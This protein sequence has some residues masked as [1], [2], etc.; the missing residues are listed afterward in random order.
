MQ[1]GFSEKNNFDFSNLKIIGLSEAR[2]NFIGYF[3]AR[4]N[5]KF[6]KEILSLYQEIENLKPKDFYELM[7]QLIRV[8]S[9]LNNLR[10]AIYQLSDCPKLANVNTIIN[11][12]LV[13]DYGGK[14]DL[15]Q[16]IQSIIFISRL[17]FPLGINMKNPNMGK[18]NSEN[19]DK[20]SFPVNNYITIAQLSDNEKPIKIIINPGK[21]KTI[22]NTNNAYSIEQEISNGQGILIGRT[23]EANSILGHNSNNLAIKAHLCFDY[24]RKNS[25]DYREQFTTFSRAGILLIRLRDRLFLFNRGSTNTIEIKNL[26][27]NKSLVYKPDTVEFSKDRLVA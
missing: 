11:S 18:I 8:N 26:K 3:K 9:K 17:A 20:Y 23:M 4:K 6:S 21:N 7:K 19:I 13:K 25:E 14:D 2:I 27:Q 16:K 1:E 24:A 12:I 15:N 5:E 10:D 22:I